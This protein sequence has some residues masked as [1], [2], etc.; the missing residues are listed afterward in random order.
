MKKTTN[1]LWGIILI[2]L[3][4]II[5]LNSFN[6][7]H[8]NI[9]FDGWWT[10]FIIVPC[11][12]G[13][14]KDEDK[15]GSIIGILVGVAL[16]LGVRKILSI[17]ML[18]KL[19]LPVILVVVGISLIL[20]DALNAETKNKIKEI[21]KGQKGTTYTATFSG[22][23]VKFDGEKFNLTEANAIFGGIKLDLRKAIIDSDCVINLSAIFGGVDILVPEDINVKIN[24]TSIFGGVSDKRNNKTNKAEHTIYINAT[25]MF[26]GADIK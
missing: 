14:F 17:D 1:V 4:V 18:L 2:A 24:S 12:I 7:T 21:N 3:G 8:I 25:C 23:D 13:L 16:L 6:I 11:V 26:G 5:A 10:L 15:T 22:Q 20:K 19:A 9:F